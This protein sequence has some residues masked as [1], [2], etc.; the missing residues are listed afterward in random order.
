MNQPLHIIPPY[1]RSADFYDELMAD[2]DYEG[3]A[4]YLMDLSAELNIRTD[5]IIDFSCGTG[6]LLH[7][8]SAGARR[9]RGLDISESMIRQAKAKYPEHEWFVGDMMTASIPEGFSL[10]L[11]LHDS[12][13]YIKDTEALK[14]YIHRMQKTCKPG[15]SL[16]FDFALPGLIEKYFIHHDETKHMRNGDIVYR[17]HDYLEGENLCLTYLE[18]THRGQRIVEIHPQRIWPFHELKEMFIGLP[19]QNLLFLEEFSYLEAH[20]QSERLLVVITHD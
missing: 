11:N 13:N 3:W 20:E 17:R 7:H 9:I 15:Q 6:T 19:G 10:G 1:S 2:I 16:Y 4:E 8:L 5:A 18:I 12:L 14:H